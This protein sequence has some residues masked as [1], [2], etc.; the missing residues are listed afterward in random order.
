M[1]C[2]YVFF[3]VILALWLP[4]CGKKELVCVLSV[5]FF[6]FFFLFFFLC[7]LVCVSFLFLLVFVIGCVLCLWHSLDFFFYTFLIRC[8]DCL[9]FLLPGKQLVGLYRGGSNEYPQSIFFCAEIRKIMY[10]PVN[11]SFTIKSEFKGSKLYRC[12]FLM[13][14][15]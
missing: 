2:A 14:N 10:T 6:C 15:A 7:L 1:L 8:F 13:P 3:S 9:L 4:G 12:V 11:P 5:F